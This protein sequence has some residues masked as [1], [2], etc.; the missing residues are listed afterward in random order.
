MWWFGNDLHITAAPEK[1]SN[2][3]GAKVIA[4]NGVPVDS[5]KKRVDE[6]ISGNSSWKKYMSLYFLRSPQVMKGLSLG[7]A[8]E[9]TLTVV[10]LKGK[11]Q[12][13]TIKAD[14]VPQSSTL[15]V[16]KDLS[17]VSVKKDSLAHVLSTKK[18]P[19]Y[20]QHADKDYSYQYLEKER[21]VYLQFNRVVDAKDI[22]FKDFTTKMIQDIGNNPFNK[23]VM[24]LRFNTG[25]NNDIAAQAL[26]ELGKFLQGKKAY[27]ITD[28]ATFSAGISAA[29]VFKKYTGAKVIGMPAGDA[30]IYLSE[31]GNVVLPNSKLNAHYANGLH[32][33]IFENG[34]SIKPDKEISVSFQDYL[35]GEDPMLNYVLKDK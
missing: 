15:E 31:G 14:F 3:L 26:V 7:N 4:I 34:F 19:L 20:L 32:N 1:H 2:I 10:P 13:V 9:L 24:D 22:S 6:L 12:T 11:E 25:G 30:L 21:T 16:W 33:D 5:V 23:F 17:P 28:V 18:L 29:A 8:D 27:I 35:N